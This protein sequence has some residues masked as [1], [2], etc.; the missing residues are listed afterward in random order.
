[1]STTFIREVTLKYRGRARK[2]LSLITGPQSAA[3]F[4]RSVLPDNVREHFVALFLA[5]S[6]EVIGFQVVA[7]G[8]ASS[9]PVHA[10]E[11]FQPAIL[12][13]ACAVLAGHNHPSNSLCPSEEDKK[14][15]KKLKEAGNLLSIPLLDH[16]IV[17][18]TGQYSLF[19]RSLF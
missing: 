7:T 2:G 6:H 4:I 14:V 9:C 12:V 18:G 8:T 3:D 13:G 16:V 1:M 11:I 15:T 10:R 17:T 5:A 19:E